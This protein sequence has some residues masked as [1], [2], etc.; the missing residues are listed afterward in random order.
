MA[1]NFSVVLQGRLLD[2]EIPFAL[3]VL[4]VTL[5]AVSSIT[6]ILG[7]TLIIVA[8]RK[9]RA[10]HVHMVF[11]AF[12]FNLALADLSVGLLVQL[13]YILAVLTAMSGYAEVSR[14]IGAL[15]YLGIWYF[16]VISIAFQ[17]VIAIDR[18]LALNVASYR[19]LVTRKRVLK[20][21]V[22]IWIMRLAETCLIIYDH[23]IFNIMANI[24]LGFCMFVITACYLKIYLTLRRQDQTVRD[25]ISLR[26]LNNSGQRKSTRVRK[27]N[28][29]L[30]KYKSSIYTM[31]YIYIAFILC[32]LPV[33][34]VMI[35]LQIQGPERPT[36]IVQFLGSTLVYINSSLNPVLYCWRIREIRRM[37]KRTVSKTFRAGRWNV[38]F[39]L[40]ETVLLKDAACSRIEVANRLVWQGRPINNVI[41][42]LNHQGNWNCTTMK[43]LILYFYIDAHVIK[44]KGKLEGRWAYWLDEIDIVFAGL[45]LVNRHFCAQSSS[46]IIEIKFLVR[47]CQAN[48]ETLNWISCPLRS[49]LL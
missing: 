21:L 18:F 26:R 43:I 48:T 34:C 42:S 24:G 20:V 5:N 22:F 4:D 35:A 31:L 10:R 1:E 17:T 44:V 33:F 7:N 14:I 16:P 12:L 8:L 41:G 19:R 15:F 3:Y 45:P 49:L 40:F 27:N 36:I 23:R 11:K 47:Y 37:V 46:N 28:F 9:I 25:M 6:T 2:P 38:L 13:P 29:N 39:T 30:V 32:S